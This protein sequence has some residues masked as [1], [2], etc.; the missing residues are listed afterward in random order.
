VPIPSTAGAHIGAA[1][2]AWCGLQLARLLLALLVLP[3]PQ[4]A[5]LLL[6]L[7]LSQPPLL[8]LE[9]PQAIARPPP[10]EACVNPRANPHQDVERV[11]Q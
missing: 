2:A 6:A 10:V 9:P 11:A 3:L 1:E 4:L 7:L 8:L 5:Q